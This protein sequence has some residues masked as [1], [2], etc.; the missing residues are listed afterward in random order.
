MIDTHAHL[1]ACA[2]PPET[3]LE[4]ARTAGV[5]R[6]VT[7]ATAVEAGLDA[8]RLAADQTGVFVAAG[9]HP[10]EAEGPDAGRL[11]ELRELLGDERVVA[12]GETGLDF[13][14]DYA[15]RGAQ[16]RLF[17]SHLGLASELQL[18]VV[19]HSRAA[20]TETSEL[21]AGFEG[22]VVLHCFSEPD[23]LPAAL[24]R[25]YYLSFAG[26]VTYPRAEDLRQAAAL[27][28][29][30]R[31]LAETDCPYLSPQPVRGNPCEPAFVMHTL[32]ELA[33]VRRA[34]ADELASRI[35]ANATRVF[36]LR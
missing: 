3:V 14:R 34:P 35:D 18:P 11:D 29:D 31:L 25:G 26:N 28:S 7:V 20:A 10:H 19:I 6:V 16:R 32:D 5:T 21:L 13:F 15:D 8:I 23:L 9:V 12:V 27:V 30:D 24:D 36:G 2:D 22:D 1:D 4:R 33:R 17:E